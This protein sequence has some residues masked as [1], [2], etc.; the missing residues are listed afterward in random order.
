TR[1]T[2]E[3]FL[4]QANFMLDNML[5]SGKILFNDPLSNYV[6]K[7]ADKL[8]INEDFQALRDEIRIYVTKSPYVNA[9]STD[10]GII[11]I[12]M[13]LLAQLE[14]EAQL[15]Y[16]IAHELIH[17]TKKHGINLYVET[18]KIAKGREGYR[19]LSLNDLYFE[20]NLRSREN[21]TEADELALIKFYSQSNYCLKEME[22]VFDVLQ[23]SYLPFDDIV[24]DTTF[25]NTK[26]FKLQNEYFLD[27]LNTIKG[28]DDYDE[29]KSTHPSV[30][31]RRRVVE[32]IIEDM[33]N[34]GRMKFILPKQDFENI[35]LQARFEVI[36]Q[37]LISR[38]YGEVIYNSYVLLKKHPDNKFLKKAIAS[39]LYGLTKYKSYGGY[40]KVCKSY[41]NIE[42]ESQ[43]V[44]HLLK[45]IDK[46]E[47]N[48]LSL[49]YCWKLHNE[50][51]NNE[52][53]HR[54]S[55]DLL[56]VLVFSSKLN[57]KKFSTKPKN[58][59]KA[60]LKSKTE[61]TDSVILSKYDEIKRKKNR[62]KTKRISAYQFAFVDLFKDEEFV[63]RFS[64]W[65]DEYQ[66]YL[67]ETDVDEMDYEARRAYYKGLKKKNKA[68]RRYGHAL[69]IDTIVMVDPAYYKIDERKHTQV[70][71]IHSER[72]QA[73]LNN[74]LNYNA[75]IAGLD[76]SLIDSK[77]LN[78]DDLDV[79][80]DLAL[81]NDW[82][83]ECFNHEEMEFVMAESQYVEG[84]IKK[85]NTK[86]FAWCVLFNVREKKNITVDEV[87]YYAFAGFTLPFFIY[88]VVWPDYYTHYYSVLYN[89]E[90]GEAELSISSDYRQ[91]DA[92][93][94]VNSKVYDT[95]FQ[96]K[97]KRKK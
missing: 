1:K 94:I 46:K 54:I 51:P 89:I 2:K 74:T 68:I 32:R 81:L 95:F 5:L 20:R 26:Y 41:K 53:L 78:S 93:D 69:G 16:I 3:K 87:C 71:Y 62:K 50:Y 15:A 13:G 64:Y 34:S 44:F 27:E 19:S 72:K 65:E 96:I 63:K 61:K 66:K 35:R 30:D 58:N 11:L 39:S 25:F 23:Y 82:V 47:L 56:K 42:G 59:I 80:N 84:L 38:D 7:V 70:R 73:E 43:Q 40:S 83:T 75:R 45:K 22:G 92:K 55:D 48:I 31:K 24:F 9:F 12:N 91:N 17:Y 97:A 4:L 8:L 79:F 36:R 49:E 18:E 60:E 86:H 67:K 10:Q 76:L 29:T 90:S 6:N 21:E 85:Y 52:Y 77:K 28:G 33:D 88:R 14:N 57:S 37:L